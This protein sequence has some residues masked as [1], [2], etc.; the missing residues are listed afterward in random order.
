MKQ[1]N[2]ETII[3]F[4]PV[5]L[6]FLVP[7]FF[8]P[9]T[10]EF[11]E[12]NKLYLVAVATLFMLLLW[13]GKMLTTKDV[14]IVRSKMDM[15]VLLLLAAV[16]VSSIFSVNKLSSI[17]G[18]TG[19]WFPTL[20]SY[21]VMIAFYYV[22]AANINSERTI[23]RSLIGLV[24]GSTVAVFIGMILYFDT[25]L[26]K[27]QF[28][29]QFNFSL[30][31]ARLTL[32]VLSSIVVGLSV[33]LM[34]NTANFTH[35]A[36]LT[37]AAL[38]NAFSAVVFGTT[39][40]MV[41][42]AFAVL[43]ALMLNG[44]N[45]LQ[46]SNVPFYGVLGAF[47]VLLVLLLSVQS[48]RNVLTNSKY[49]IEPQ[50]GF[51]EAWRT[52]ISSLRDFPVTGSGP[53]TYYLNYTRYK[54]PAQNFTDAWNLRFDRPN[55]EI[56][57]V[58]STMGL[59]GIA[60]YAFFLI[61]A[62]KF[63]LKNNNELSNTVAVLQLAVLASMFVTY[64]TVLTGFLLFLSLALQAASLS[65]AGSS[66]AQKVSLSISSAAKSFSLMGDQE[67]G[68][69]KEVFH[70]MV[71]A[72]LAAGSLTMG[73]FLT[74]YYL[75]EYYMRQALNAATQNNGGA[76][77]ANVGRAISFNPRKDSY[78]TFLARTSV[79]LANS[80]ENKKTLSDQDK[81]TIQSLI[82]QA[83]Q[84]SR[85]ATEVLNP[86]NSDNWET[87]AFVYGS[88]RSATKDAYGLELQ[89]YNTAIRLDPTNPALRVMAGGAYYA[90]EEYLAAGN[91][92][93]QAVNLK[94]NYANARYNLAYALLKLKSYERAKQEFV[95]VQK[96]ITT[97]SKDYERIA[98]EIKNL[99]KLI[100]QAKAN[101]AQNVAG[102]SDAKLSVEDLEGAQAAPTQQG[103]LTP[104]AAGQP[105]IDSTNLDG[106]TN[107]STP[108]GN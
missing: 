42:A 84:S 108:S 31:G 59:V 39:G 61:S 18:A 89:S 16:V 17:Y 33:S 26:I 20:I 24:A 103:P 34:G 49:P 82:L 48:T 43:A 2:L 27:T 81:Q 102:T 57:N 47:T 94:N 8:L 73:Y 5:L 53:S 38:L 90:K 1:K 3:N 79:A 9:I 65:L 105:N 97:E 62:I 51:G 86:L 30:T 72:L 104:P 19:R 45:I 13:A 83:V 91:L 64:G 74:R 36:M 28:L 55:N 100:A 32:A 7:F 87:R 78:H 12:F 99:D 44:R 106:I 88:L 58:V 60:A 68:E 69:K 6:S 22:S 52:S 70:Y 56:L 96:L 66:K 75:G 40:T 67:H 10:V 29:S 21:I 11:F 71:A 14:S 63:A 101:S 85:L 95:A 76:T 23:K 35:K 50:L 41:L 80:I 54:S 92:F 15:P 93:A 37:G 25:G 98:T 46:K 77:Y 4:I 107:E